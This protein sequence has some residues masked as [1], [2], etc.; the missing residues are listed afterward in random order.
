[1]GL[2]SLGFSAQVITYPQELFLD[3]L[4]LVSCMLGRVGHAQD[5]ACYTKR[6]CQLYAI[7][8]DASFALH[9]RDADSR[10]LTSVFLCKYCPPY[11]MS[12]NEFNFN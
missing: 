2:N 7:L 11:Q 4:A 12:T 5:I 8:V 10:L 1:M 3:N 9:L 6:Y